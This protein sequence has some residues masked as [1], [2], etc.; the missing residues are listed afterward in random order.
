VINSGGEKIQPEVIE[1]ILYTSGLVEQCLVY[2]EPSDKWGE[3]VV[4][5]ICPG[6]T[7]LEE[8]KRYTKSK[9]PDYMHP[10]VWKLMDEIPL[11]E[12]GKRKK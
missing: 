3:S 6:N 7:K 2:G 9:I 12:M 10:K 11:S 8:L 5:L 1:R 4:A